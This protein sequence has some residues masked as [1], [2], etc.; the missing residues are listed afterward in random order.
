MQMQFLMMNIPDDVPQLI[1]GKG[2]LLV[3][4]EPDEITIPFSSIVNIE[5]LPINRIYNPSIGF[6][7]GGFKGF[8]A[9]RNSGQF[10]IYFNYFI[11]LDIYTTAGNYYFESLDLKNASEFI[12][13]LKD[14]FDIEDDA[15]LINLFQTRT[16]TEIRDYMDRHYKDL[17]KTY[18]LDN[19]RV[20]LDESMVRLVNKTH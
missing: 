12:L 19:P 8:M 20:T 3:K 16:I 15:G 9:H 18:D 11:D 10:S 2:A 13:K 6:L 14:H 1:L 5:I 17:A 7:K 4:N